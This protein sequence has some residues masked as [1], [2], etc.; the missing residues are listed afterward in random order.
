MEA[1]RA[2]RHT[3]RG[4]KLL[5]YLLEHGSASTHD[6]ETQLGEAHAPSAVRDLNDRG[7]RVVLDGY[8]QVGGKRRGVY[9]LDPDAPVRAGMIGRRGF[10]KAFKQRLIE[11]YGARCEIC[12]VEYEPRYLQPDHRV[13]QRV[14]GDEPDTQRRVED[15]MPVCRSGNRAKSF[16]CER[17]PNWEAR[18]VDVCMSCYWAFPDSYEHVATRQER[19]VAIVWSGAETK[20]YDRLWREAQRAGST[21]GEV[22]KRLIANGRP[23]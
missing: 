20:I 17:C 13:P 3:S 11:H 21:V 8:V 18:D 4:K 7:V 16:E 12:R 1:A 23:R 15:Y 9:K 6:I 5:E 10:S 2:V 22:V 14:G 19:R